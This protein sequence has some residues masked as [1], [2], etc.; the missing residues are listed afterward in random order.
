M[1]KRGIQ[2]TEVWN[3]ETDVPTAEMSGRTTE[4][5]HRIKRGSKLND[6]D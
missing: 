6:E 4:R 5:A 2:K 3:L 1:E